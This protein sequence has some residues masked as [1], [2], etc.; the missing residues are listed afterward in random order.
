MPSE[1]SEI[2]GAAMGSG[3][4]TGTMRRAGRIASMAGGDSGSAR[5]AEAA[6]GRT[7]ARRSEAGDAW[8]VAA[9]SARAEAEFG[10]PDVRVGG[11]GS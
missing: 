3:R 2:A 5:A 1:G 7:L 6:G 9:P 11:R 10:P 8:A 4:E